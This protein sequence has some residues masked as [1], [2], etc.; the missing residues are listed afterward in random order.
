MTGYPFAAKVWACSRAEELVDSKV[1]SLVWIGSDCLVVQPPVLLALDEGHD[2]AVRP[3][4]IRNV[5]LAAT[6]PVD[7]FWTGVFEA[8][9]VDDVTLVAESFVDQQRLRAYFNSHMVSVRPVRGI[10]RRWF[11]RF[12][13]LATDQAFQAGACSDPLHR[14]FLHQAVLSA[15]LATEVI[16]ERLRILPPSYSYPYNLQDRVPPHRRATLLN[17]LVCVACEDRPLHPDEITD[18]DIRE[19]LRSWLAARVPRSSP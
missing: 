3:V 16:W 8:I 14:V 7:R 6:G 10:Y 13:Q 17:D 9:G 12:A 5:G 15:L 2:A 19:P 4:H 11:E 1:Q 18:I